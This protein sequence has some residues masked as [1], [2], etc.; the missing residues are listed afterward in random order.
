MNK[1]KWFA[2]AVV[3]VV[4]A[5][6]L[7]LVF[8]LT[9]SQPQSTQPIQASLNPAGAQSEGVQVHGHWTIEVR[10]PDGSLANRQ[11]FDNAL[12]AAGGLALANV[13]TRNDTVGPW[14]IRLSGPDSPWYESG[15]PANGLINE[16]G[17][18]CSSYN[19]CSATL[20]VTLVPWPPKMVLRGNITA[21]QNGNINRVETM[22]W[23]CNNTLSPSTCGHADMAHIFL[24]TA[25]DLPTLQAVLTD[26][27]IL[28]EVD[29]SFQ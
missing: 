12:T 26:Q 18:G 29:I 6:T 23:L 7:G 17:W 10:N 21:S 11:E 27:Q 14:M 25:T 16:P 4:A 15:G 3:V 13:L 24:F 5:V 1:K 22:L 8:G 19:Y 2:A 28:V 9:G 20:T